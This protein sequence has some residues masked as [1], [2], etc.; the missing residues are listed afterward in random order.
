LL[1]RKPGWI[2]F[3]AGAIASGTATLDG[4]SEEL[5]QLVLDV[6]SGRKATKSEING[7]R[8]IAIWKDG[9]TL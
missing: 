3:G 7:Y 5:F 6:A 4:L 2:D 1:N 8:E 9:V